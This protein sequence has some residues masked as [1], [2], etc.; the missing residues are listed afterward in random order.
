M[1]VLHDAKVRAKAAAEA[2]AKMT[3]E[4]RQKAWQEARNREIAS[5]PEG[6]Q[7]F[8]WNGKDYDGDYADD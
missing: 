7:H 3:E 2:A 8:R 4:A 1:E 5:R 6:W